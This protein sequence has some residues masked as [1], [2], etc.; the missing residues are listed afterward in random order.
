MTKITTL[1]EIYAAI[2]P[3]PAMLSSKGKVSPSAECRIEANAGTSIIL[4][5]H[6][7]YALNDWENEYQFF[8]GDDFAQAIGKA[9]AFIDG[10]PS[11]EQAKLHNFMGKLGSIIDAAPWR[12]H[13]GLIPQPARGDHEEAFRERDHASAQARGGLIVAFTNIPDD[14][15]IACRNQNLIW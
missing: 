5:Y 4:R 11:A 10:L 7:A 15:R 9:L 13:R 2:N 1:D 8:A 3:L 6:K 12:R 14:R